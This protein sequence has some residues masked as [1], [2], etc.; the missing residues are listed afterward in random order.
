MS[1]VAQVELCSIKKDRAEQLL[2]ALG[3]EKT[4]WTDNAHHLAQVYIYLTGDMLLAAGV[5]AYLGAFTPEYRAEHATR[6]LRECRERG[7]PC[8]GEFVLA[9]VRTTTDIHGQ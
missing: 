1:C 8:S 7:V 4:R 2:A 5:I 9:S 3:G 6:W